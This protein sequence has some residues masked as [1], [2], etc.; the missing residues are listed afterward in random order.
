MINESA[1]V[2]A[3][4]REYKGLGYD[5]TNAT[6]RLYIR[7]GIWFAELPWK[8]VPG[9]VLGLI[10]EHLRGMPAPGETIHLQNGEEPQTVLEDMAA[11]DLSLWLNTTINPW[12]GEI[13][14][15]MLQAGQLVIFQDPHT[16][17]SYGLPD[18]VADIAEDAGIAAEVYEDGRCRWVMED[19]V[20]TAMCFRPGFT[21]SVIYNPLMRLWDALDTTDLLTQ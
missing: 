18:Y 6:D 10:A 7:G 19:G 11:T 5:I 16:R 2:R 20:I 9:K 17:K 8:S 15:T 12:S 4:K 21:G 14:R 3:M 1:L 13:E